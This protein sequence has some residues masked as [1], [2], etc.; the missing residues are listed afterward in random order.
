MRRGH[1]SLFQVTTSL[2]NWREMAYMNILQTHLGKIYDHAFYVCVIW[3]TQAFSLKNH[4]GFNTISYC[5][6]VCGYHRQPQPLAEL[7]RDMSICCGF[8]AVAARGNIR[9]SILLIQLIIGS[10]CITFLCYY[11][12][13]I[14][15]CVCDICTMYAKLQRNSLPCVSI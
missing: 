1:P 2:L 9:G 11:H 8:R 13:Y 5:S 12:I 6:D 7:C 10:C 15:V 4:C 14:Y 3:D